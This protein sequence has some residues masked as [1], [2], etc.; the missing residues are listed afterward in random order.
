MTT[1]ISG[2]TIDALAVEAI[3]M[4]SCRKEKSGW[5]PNVLPDRVILSVSGVKVTTGL[6]LD[7]SGICGLWCVGGVAGNATASVT[8]TLNLTVSYEK[9]NLTEVTDCTGD[10]HVGKTEFVG[11]KRD[12]AIPEPP[13]GLPISRIICYGSKPPGALMDALVDVDVTNT[14]TGKQMGGG[15]PFAGLVPLLNQKFAEVAPRFRQA[16]ASMQARQE[17]RRAKWG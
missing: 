12:V 14:K 9:A 6:H 3:R 7:S 17:A 5:L 11:E 15:P 1:T 8:G 10:F 4:R 16:K 13:V 2:I